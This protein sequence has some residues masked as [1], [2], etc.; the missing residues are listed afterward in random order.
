MQFDYNKDIPI[1]DLEDKRSTTKAISWT[2]KGVL[3][4]DYFGTIY[5]VYCKP[6]PFVGECLRFEGHYNAKT[7]VKLEDMVANIVNGE[8]HPFTTLEEM[9]LNGRKKVADDQ[10]IDD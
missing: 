10:N 4:L 2:S 8:K 7:K 5:Q 6:M 3:K 9:I 1:K